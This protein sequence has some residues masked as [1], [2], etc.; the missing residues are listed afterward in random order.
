M[1][2]KIYTADTRPL[3]NQA[4]YD[5]LIRLVP[6][7]RRKITESRRQADDR[8]ASLAAGLLLSLATERMG[9]PGADE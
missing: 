3:K 4:T 7:Q 1:Y 6:E 8:A 5:R 9:L 2:L